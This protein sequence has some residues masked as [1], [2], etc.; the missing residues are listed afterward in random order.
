MA[1]KVSSKGC[2]LYGMVMMGERVACGVGG[3]KDGVRVDDLEKC[4][5]VVDGT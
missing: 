1:S 5:M 3:D 2:R 4:R